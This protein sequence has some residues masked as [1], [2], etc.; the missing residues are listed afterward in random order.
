MLMAQQWGQAGFVIT[1]VTVG[2]VPLAPA[3]AQSARD[4][5][6]QASFGDTDE[7]SALRRVGNA[8]AAAGNALRREPD[9]REA[10]LMRATALGYRAKL[11]GNRGD[12]VAA[13]RQFEALITQNPR[14]A[15]AQAALGAWHIGAVKKLGA[16]VGRAALGAQ[17]SIG[18][19]ALERAVALGG[20]RALF[21]GLAALLRL[22]LDPRDPRGRALAEQAMR[23]EAPTALDRILQ[24]GAAQ[25]L[26]P[27]RAGD[28]QTARRLASQ[29]LPF[30]RFDDD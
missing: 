30:G 17:R 24:R 22:E 25:V 13:R 12:A 1:I 2:A 29:L 23:A 26:V 9:D 28:A 20:D 8:Y 15:E 19:S 7:A 27:L 3:H 4:I 14:D 11:T 16:I 18:M 6:T 5:L 21:P 10:L